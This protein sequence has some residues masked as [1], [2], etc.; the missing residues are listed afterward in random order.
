MLKGELTEKQALNMWIM[1]YRFMDNVK[2][3]MDTVYKEKVGNITDNETS[4]M[5]EYIRDCLND[6]VK[7]VLHVE[8]KH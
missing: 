8:N 1:T 3:Y 2:T 5:M 4:K 7:G 6:I